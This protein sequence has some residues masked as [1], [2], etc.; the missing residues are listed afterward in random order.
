MGSQTAAEEEFI[1]TDAFVGKK[2]WNGREPNILLL[3][4]GDGFV[5]TGAAFGVDGHL[6]G[7]G[8]AAADFDQDGDTDFAINNYM[9]PAELWENQVGARR[10]WLAVRLQGAGPNRDAVG[11]IVRAYVG[12]EVQT[13]LVGAGHGYAS[14]YS[15]E[16]LFGLGDAAEV[17]Q[18]VV[19]WPTTGEGAPGRVEAF[20][21]FAARSRVRLIE[22]QGH[23]PRG[24]AAT[25]PRRP[26]PG[27]E[28]ELG[29]PCALAALGL[30][31]LA[32]TPLLARTTPRDEPTP[33]SAGGAAAPPPQA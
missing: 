10:G 11:A 9:A 12:D 6:D 7:R 23:P 32:L 17:E 14:Q 19:T 26:T 25:A 1:Y 18:V 29:V 4:L 2:S 27:A 31:L 21:P 20:G 28:G 15:L 5:E 3:N 24:A 22:G 8:L 30:L 16:Q 33:P 13:R